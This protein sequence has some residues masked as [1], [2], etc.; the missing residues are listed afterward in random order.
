[1]TYGCAPMF[2]SCFRVGLFYPT[3][4]QRHILRPHILVDFP[5]NL[6][7]L[8][9]QIVGVGTVICHRLI[10]YTSLIKF[11]RNGMLS[12]PYAATLAKEM[13]TRCT[14]LAPYTST[15]VNNLPIPTYTSIDFIGPNRK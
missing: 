15:T 4:S 9:F 1:M 10:I 2:L 11:S 3:R 13:S 8:D 5:R 12:P 6:L 7:T 14:C